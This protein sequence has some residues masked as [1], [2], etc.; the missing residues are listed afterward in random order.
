MRAVPVFL[1]L[2]IVYTPVTFAQ[3]PRP[4]IQA[5]P[6]PTQQTVVLETDARQV[7]EQLE[8]LLMKYPPEV[9][10]ILKMDP[11]MLL[12]QQYLGQYPALQQFL[13]AHPEVARNPTF[14]LEFVRQSYDYTAPD[15][16]QSRSARI[17]YDMFEAVG[18]FVIVVFISSMVMWLAKTVLNHRR[19]LRTFRVQS[20]V[21]TKLLDR[22]AGTSELLAYIQTPP[23]Q[24]FLE[25]APIPV[26]ASSD[27]Q[28]GAPLSRILWAVQAGIVLGMGGLAF[29]YVSGRVDQEVGPGFWVIGVLMTALGVG[30]ILAGAFSFVMT[31]RLGLLD[32]VPPLPGR[33]RTDST[34]V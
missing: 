21:H 24:R 14:F 2:A 6:A 33:E 5:P 11:T 32:P 19:W 13:A 10:R 8:A 30:F 7:R 9:G 34:A 4:A 29:Q 16:P 28:L 3:T 20:D 25:A 23:G 26:E 12:N 15:D 27:R 1:A 31:R 17:W 22:F 18:V